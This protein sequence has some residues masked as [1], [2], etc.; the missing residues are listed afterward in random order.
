MG[1]DVF[2]SRKEVLVWTTGQKNLEKEI[3][4]KTE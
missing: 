4:K 2:T 3:S 1:N